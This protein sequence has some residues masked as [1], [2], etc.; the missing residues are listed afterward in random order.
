MSK[1]FGRFV[2][3]FLR[4]KCRYSYTCTSL[5]ISVTV[6]IFTYFDHSQIS[7][8]IIACLQEHIVKEFGN[9]LV[10]ICKAAL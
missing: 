2:I 1:I 4:W 9:S 3:N 6:W 10:L 5:P 7:Q 8:I